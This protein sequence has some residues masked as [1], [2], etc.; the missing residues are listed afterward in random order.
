M[1]LLPGALIV[2][3]FA[4]VLL[5][6]CI[7][8]DND[9]GAASGSERELRESL[10]EQEKISARDPA[11]ATAWLVKGNRHQLLREFNAADTV[12]DRVLELDPG[13]SLAWL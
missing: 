12:Y 10:R 13:I 5:C 3:L 8:G 6:G 9:Q 2:F 11:N 1:K 4:G 7:T